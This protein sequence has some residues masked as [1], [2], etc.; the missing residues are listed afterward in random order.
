MIGILAK[1]VEL[2]LKEAKNASKNMKITRTHGL[3]D[4]LFKMKMWSRWYF[5]RGL[6][7]CWGAG[8]VLLIKLFNAILVAGCPTG[9]ERAH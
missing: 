2:G 1:L 4:F 9:G 5:Y 3:E 8:V 6:E 7:I